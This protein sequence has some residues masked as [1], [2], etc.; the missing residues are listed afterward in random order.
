MS[1]MFPASF[2]EGFNVIPISAYLPSDVESNVESLAASSSSISSLRIFERFLPPLSFSISRLE[3]QFQAQFP[4]PSL[5]PWS[6][7]VLPTS[8]NGPR[9]AQA[10]RIDL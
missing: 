9:Q 1:M 6:Y 5:H 7:G 3:N 4:S 10:Q 2:A 8:S